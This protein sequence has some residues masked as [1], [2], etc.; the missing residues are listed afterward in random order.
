[1]ISF[2]APGSYEVKIKCEFQT[3]HLT[4]LTNTFHAYYIRRELRELNTRDRKDFLDT[5]ITMS[6]TP[7]AEGIKLYGKQYRS[8][9]DFEVMHLRA[10]GAR[11]VDHIHDGLGGV[12]QHAAMT[13]EFEL[14]MQSVQP[15]LAV[16][17]QLTSPPR[18]N[19]AITISLP[20]A[21]PL[22]R[23]GAILGLHHRLD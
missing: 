6:K 1:M 18:A 12:T 8:L 4:T 17:D 2:P 3:G 23:I 22:P 5:F 10:A 14:A 11:R 19:S 9:A 13:M 21:S 7:T 16:R 20:P 15:R